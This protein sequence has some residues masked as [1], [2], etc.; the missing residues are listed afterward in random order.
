MEVIVFDENFAEKLFAI[1]NS[2]E[3]VEILNGT[4]L[5]TSKISSVQK[6]FYP[7][8]YISKPILRGAR[9]YGED[10]KTMNET[11]LKELAIADKMCRE[12]NSNAEK[13]GSH[14]FIC[15]DFQPNAHLIGKN[16]ILKPGW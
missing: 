4:I 7:S 13:Q 11:V 16:Y 8:F 1:W 2:V 14:F 6:V 12:N 10:L 9:G 5:T 3:K 15:Q